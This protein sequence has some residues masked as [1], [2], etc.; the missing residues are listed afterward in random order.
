[1]LCGFILTSYKL[2]QLLIKTI[3]IV[4]EK[5]CFRRDFQLFKDISFVKKKVEHQ[6]LKEARKI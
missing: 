1:M 2:L 3:K 6:K 5:T 4:L